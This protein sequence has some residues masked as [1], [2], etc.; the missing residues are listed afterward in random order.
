MLYTTTLLNHI[1][2]ISFPTDLIFY[3]FWMIYHFIFKDRIGGENTELYNIDQTSL[4]RK[5]DT[6][7]LWRYMPV[8]G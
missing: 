6:I 1:L 3:T 7:N 4:W 2:Y 5:V 8:F